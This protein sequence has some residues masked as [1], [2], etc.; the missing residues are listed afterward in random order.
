M[1]DPRTEGR[2]WLILKGTADGGADLIVSRQ[3]PTPSSSAMAMLRMRGKAAAEEQT[4]HIYPSP[5]VG[6]QKVELSATLIDAYAVG[7]SVGVDRKRIACA[8][9][10]TTDSLIVQ[11]AGVPTL[12]YGI[13]D[14]VCTENGWVRVGFYRPVLA[15]GANNTIPI[16][17]TALR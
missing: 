15:V 16:K 11:P 13:I 3:D 12:G 8:G 1:I 5:T 10:R 9:V 4:V 2:L 6:A 17:I 14:A 7:L